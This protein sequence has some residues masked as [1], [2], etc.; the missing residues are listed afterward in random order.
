MCPKAEPPSA[1]PVPAAVRRKAA[2]LGVEEW[3]V[4][5]PAIVAGLERDWGIDV[6][7]DSAYDDATEAFV[8]AATMG[9]LPVVVKIHLPGRG[10]AAAREVT[11]LRLA[12]GEGS[13]AMIREDLDRGALLLER[14][15]PSLAMSDLGTMA[16][17][18]VLVEAARRMWRPAADS[19]LPTAAEKGRRLSE[20]I[21]ATWEELDRPCNAAAVHLA[22]ACAEARARA[23]RERTAVLVHGDVHQWNALRAGDGY[24]LVD[25]DGLLAEPEY[26]LGIIMREDPS[27]LDGDGWARAEWLAARSGLRADAIWQWGAAERVATG[28]LLTRIGV[29]PVGAEMLAAAERVASRQPIP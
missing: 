5:L 19:G 7:V 28:L 23:H 16:R 15:G 1:L 26:D 14:L 22:R 29:Q 21:E 12:A 6:D 11:V 9:G 10:E 27:E 8:A 17:H 13:V 24:K 2:A 4:Q 25:P 3:L 18:E 20:F